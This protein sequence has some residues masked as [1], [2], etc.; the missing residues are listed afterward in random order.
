MSMEPYRPPLA[1]MP[2][3]ARALIN[4]SGNK[5]KISN[6]INDLYAFLAGM[7]FLSAR[8]EFAVHRYM[9]VLSSFILGTYE[10][11]LKS[12]SQNACIYVDRI[13]ARQ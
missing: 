11:P 3:P 5:I 4:Y 8:P 2:M 12:T 7:V 13:K 9:N 10:K 1:W 6:K